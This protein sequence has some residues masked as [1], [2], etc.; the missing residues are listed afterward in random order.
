MKEELINYVKDCFDGNNEVKFFISERGNQRV[1]IKDL[2]TGEIWQTLEEVSPSSDNY[3]D[4]SAALIYSLDHQS[5]S[6]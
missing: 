5:E 6:L 2:D 1:E 3:E 4:I